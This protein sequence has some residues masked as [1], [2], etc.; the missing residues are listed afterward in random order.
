MGTEP[1]GEEKGCVDKLMSNAMDTFEF[2]DGAMSFNGMLMIFNLA[3]LLICSFRWY[4]EYKKTG[5]FMDY[6]TGFYF[7]YIILPILIMYPFSGSYY[8]VISV[9]KDIFW[10]E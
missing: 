10:K 6:M 1:F 2:M 9:G 8:N 4:R 5:I 3:L 7:I